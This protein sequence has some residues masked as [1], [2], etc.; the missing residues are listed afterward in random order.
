MLIN[1]H[2]KA[3]ACIQLPPDFGNIAWEDLVTR[4]QEACINLPRAHVDSATIGPHSRDQPPFTEQLPDRPTRPNTSAGLRGA[5]QVCAFLHDQ[6][7][8]L[9][10]L[11]E[12]IH[13]IQDKLGHALGG[14]DTDE[15]DTHKIA[16]FG[17]S[18]LPPQ[19]TPLAAYYLR[20]MIRFRMAQVDFEF[21]SNLVEQVFEAIGQVL[22]GTMAPAVAMS[23]NDVDELSTQHGAWESVYLEINLDFFELSSGFS[24]NTL[25]YKD[26]QTLREFKRARA[27]MWTPPNAI[28]C[29]RQA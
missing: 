21:V 11:I 1:M 12:E 5:R 29:S 7:M 26:Q 17:D 9:K 14:F 2:S 10:V 24:E 28:C 22:R 15:I 27:R 23:R 25:F 18:S 13:D 6:L 19:M 3:F 20:A 8:Y 16:G 4:Y